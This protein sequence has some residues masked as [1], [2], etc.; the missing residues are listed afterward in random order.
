LVYLGASLSSSHGTSQRVVAG[1]HAISLL[2]ALL[3]RLSVQDM[4]GP[5]AYYK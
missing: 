3:C 5:T 4:A 1:T 2:L